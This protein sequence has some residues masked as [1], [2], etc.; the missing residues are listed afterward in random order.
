MKPKNRWVWVDAARVLAIYLVI[1]VH[2][3]ANLPIF[4]RL[5]VPLFVML[6]GAM[7]LTKNESY[8]DFW[9]KR[10]LRLLKPW[11]FWALVIT[12][13]EIFIKKTVYNSF[14][15]LLRFNFVKIWFVPMLF[16]LYLLTPAL[17]ILVKRA[18][19]ADLWWLIGL[20]FITISIW[21]YFRN[22]AAFPLVS[23]NG[24]V[25]QVVQFSGYYLLGWVMIRQNWWGKNVNA[26]LMAVGILITAIASR[27]NIE[28]LNYLAPGIILLSMGVFGLLTNMKIYIQKTVKGK[29]AE[30]LAITSKTSLGVYFTHPLILYLI[31][32]NIYFGGWISA[33]LLLVI[34]VVMILILQMVPGLKKWVM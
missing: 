18:R 4:S 16:G 19:M 2:T 31:P 34:S 11:M 15:G 6:S 27:T 23:D 17:R 29:K 14:L 24:L 22:T 1:V 26:A 20:W 8:S 7:L 10:L 3:S 32:L 30:I 13:F 5:G 21:P 25:R 12:L 28:F 33:F 9:S